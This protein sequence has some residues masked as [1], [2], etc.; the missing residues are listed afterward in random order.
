[1]IES[2]SR[3]V[4]S[5]PAFA[6]DDSN[7]SIRMA[8]MPSHGLLRSARNDG[9]RGEIH[10]CLK[11]CVTA[12]PSLPILRDA[13]LQRAPQDEVVI[14]GANSDPHG[15]EAHRAVSNHVARLLFEIEERKSSSL[16]IIRESG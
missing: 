2:K 11:S 14:S 8:S 12:S 1:M 16:V 7:R 10:R 13:R 9:V 6:G 4:L 5:S 15:E 3:G